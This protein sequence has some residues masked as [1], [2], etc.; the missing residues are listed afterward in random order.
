MSS[1]E[2]PSGAA[3][4]RTPA[5]PLG[6]RAA[7]VLLRGAMAA[8][9]ALLAAGS[10]LGPATREAG[11]QGADIVLSG[12]FHSAN[13]IRAHVEP[14]VGAG[15]C[16]RVTIVGSADVAG[17]EK[18]TVVPVSRWLTRTI[19]AVPAR[20][21]TFAWVSLRTRPHV[22]GGFH[23]LVNGLVAVVVARWIGARAWYFCVGGPR[24][25]A[26]G[27]VYAE[28]AYFERLQVPDPWIER[29]L[30]DAVR[31]CDLVI[32]MGTTA[33]EYFLQQ[34]VR[35]CEVISG[36]IDPGR[37]VKEGDAPAVPAFDL[38]VAARLV[39]VKRLERFL[40]VV[41]RLAGRRPDISAVLVGD[42]PLRAT[43]ED[44]SRQ[45]GVETH[46]TFAGMQSDVAQWLRKGRVF[47]LTSE[48]EGLPLAAMEALT[49]GLPVVAPRV[50]DLADL[51][52]DGVNGYLVPEGSIEGLATAAASLLEN[53]DDLRRCSAAARDSAIRYHLPAAVQRWEAVLGAGTMR[54]T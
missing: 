35:R 21:L 27:G 2:S 1:G 20:L 38:I 40:A 29:R 31:A 10:R 5:L 7:R 51:V 9:G 50:G 15:R 25:A 18:V 23:L 43:L 32:T 11:P 6:A 36:G 48:S 12:T 3:G 53:P 28:N 4:A 26:D 52:E 47:M 33:R 16:R 13:W 17:L 44:L 42:G 8:H 54:A 37:F 41:Q 22:V 30:L 24:E 34:G 46:V 39:P 45:L 49:C 19:G 14:L